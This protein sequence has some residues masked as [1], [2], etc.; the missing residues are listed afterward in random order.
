MA[1]D[2]LTGET[3]DGN[4]QF[5]ARCQ[6]W[7]QEMSAGNEDSLS[8]L[9]NATL[10]KVFGVAIRIVSDATLAE[11]VVIDVYHEAWRS[12]ARYKRSRGRPITWLLTICRN[13]A[14]DE[15]RHET[16]MARKVETAAAMEMPASVAEPV[17]LLEVT[18][19]GHVVQSLLSTISPDDR[20]LLALAFSEG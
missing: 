20:Q 3:S 15:I 2:V 12:A 17:D 13:R 10:N 18:E 16:S 9:F 11:D 7:L 19:A 6:Q 14:L 8:E 4:E 1:P 5:D